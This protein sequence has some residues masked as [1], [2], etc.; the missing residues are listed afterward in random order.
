MPIKIPSNLPANDILKGENIF[1]ITEKRAL[2]QDIR[3]LKIALLNIMPTKIVTET[4]LIRLLGNTPLQVE[5]DFVRT[6]TYTGK[7]TSIE[8]MNS[9]YKSFDDIKNNK[10]DGMII[11]GAPVELLEFSDVNYWNE[12]EEILEWTKTNVTSTFHICWAALAGLYYHY[13]IQKHSL[14]KKLSG[15]YLHKVNRKKSMLVRGFDDIFYAPHSRYSTVKTS[16]IRN[17]KRLQLISESAEAGA[18]IIASKDKKQIFVTG[19]GEYDKDTLKYEYE[20]DLNAGKNPEI[21][22][23]YFE[24]NDPSKEP[25]V[26]WRSHANLLFYNWLNY[27][28]YQTTPYDINEI[29]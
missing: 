23:N 24:N 12:L 17:E 9:F 3:P 2:T 16:D 5:I 1:C 10:Y 28:V 19:H 6:S 15:I 11:T 4:Q 21:P 20:R 27:Y 18:Y 26:R 29:K 13:G 7:N 8:H 22:V 25:I 14:D